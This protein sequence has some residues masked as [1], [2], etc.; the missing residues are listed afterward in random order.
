MLVLSRKL[1]EKITIGDSIVLTIVQINNGT[2]RIGIQAPRD[3]S[4]LRNELLPGE[5]PSVESERKRG[6]GRVENL[7]QNLS[8]SADL[9]TPSPTE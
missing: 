6:R 7:S 2:V 4:V 8:C 9:S 1:S 3:V 5:V